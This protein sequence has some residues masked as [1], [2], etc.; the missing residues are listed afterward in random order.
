MESIF[1]LISL[2]SMSN[3]IFEIGRSNN[4]LPQFDCPSFN[5]IFRNSSL[6]I[7]LIF[8]PLLALL[9]GDKEF[10]A[11][12]IP[13]FFCYMLH[14]PPLFAIIYISA[15]KFTRGSHNNFS[16]HSK[17]IRKTFRIKAVAI[18]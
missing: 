11:L 13:K 14:S 8:L 6:K 18:T 3:A 4:A 2:D 1:Y 7:L 9:Q 15:S 12:C 16:L 17:Y 10:F 5:L